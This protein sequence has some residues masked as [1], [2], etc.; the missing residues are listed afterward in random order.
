L[1]IPEVLPPL[2]ISSISYYRRSSKPIFQTR[3][4]GLLDIDFHMAHESLHMLSEQKREAYPNFG[5]VT[6]EF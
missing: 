4:H 5:G 6:K 2:D 3:L 1:A